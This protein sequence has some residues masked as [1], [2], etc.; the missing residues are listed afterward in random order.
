MTERRLPPVTA[1]GM[2]SLALIVAGGI[3]I[4]SNLPGTVPLGPAIVLLAASVLLLASN[5]IALSRVPGFAWW[6][7]FQVAKW[8]LLGYG[9]TAALI[10]YA[11]VRNDV[12]GGTLVVLTLSLAVYAVHVPVLIA[13][14]VARYE[15]SPAP[16][17][18]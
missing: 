9:V 14:T 4:A 11:F 12:S 3:Y 18:V 17:A 8:A 2:L 5:L 15:D 7:F 16:S 6:R 1:I 10:E 13:F